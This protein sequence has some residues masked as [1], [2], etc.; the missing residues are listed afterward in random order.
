M[1]KIGFRYSSRM[2]V[3]MSRLWLTRYRIAGLFFS[4]FFTAQCGLPGSPSLPKGENE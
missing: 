3:L 4:L 1:S 2:R